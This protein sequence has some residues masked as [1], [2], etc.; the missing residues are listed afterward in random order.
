M[1]LDPHIKERLKKTFT[2][3]SIAQK[4]LVK[5]FSSYRL[6]QDELKKI[7]LQFPQYAMNKVENKV[8]PSLIGGFV[9]QCGS[10]N[11]DLSIRNA[12]HLLKQQLYESN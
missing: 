6:S 11:I 5:I 4:E 12:L 3:E 9:I 2:E 1:H 8:D 10:Q 7:I